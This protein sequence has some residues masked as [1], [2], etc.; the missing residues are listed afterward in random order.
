MQVDTA[1]Q[2][3]T[4]PSIRR[5]ILQGVNI[6]L[7]YIGLYVMAS[8]HCVM[9]D[10]I[11][12][13]GL[14]VLAGIYSNRRWVTYSI[15][16]HIIGC[17]MIDVVGFYSVPY[18]TGALILFLFMR[19]YPKVNSAVWVAVTLTLVRLPIIVI[20][21]FNP[22][23]ASML[24]IE[25]GLSTVLLPILQRFTTRIERPYIKGA[26]DCQ[27]LM[28]LFLVMCIAIISTAEMAFPMDI[29]LSAMLCG[30][31]I[32]LM[33]L[34]GGF[35][36]GG[37]TGIILGVVSGLYLSPDP[38]IM[39]IYGV[40]GLLCGLV[41]Q[42]GKW[43]VIT[44]FIL[45]SCMFIIITPLKVPMAFTIG[46]QLAAAVLILL[47]SEKT[48]NTLKGIVNSYFPEPEYA[49]RLKSAVNDRLVQTSVALDRLSGY[50]KKLSH[51]HPDAPSQD[52]FT[53][54]DKAANRVCKNCISSSNCWQRDY[55]V[56]A[57]ALMD[58]SHYLEE[59]GYIEVDN[60]PSHL[61]NRCEKI[62][63][64][65]EQVN[66]EYESY[67]INQVLH[68]KN[69]I[70]EDLAARQIK[71]FSKIIQGINN[72][73][74]REI[75]FDTDLEKR[76]LE[77]LSPLPLAIHS[78]NAVIDHTGRYSITITASS[79]TGATIEEITQ[80]ISE[81]SGKEMEPYDMTEEHNKVTLH[82]TQAPQYQLEYG[83][84]SAPKDGQTISGDSRI[85]AKLNDGRV[86]MAISD[87]MGSGE[88]AARQ[89]DATIELLGKFFEA[90]FDTQAALRMINSILLLRSGAESFATLD[91]AIIDKYSAKCEFIKIGANCGYVLINGKIKKIPSGS[92]PA[93]ILTEVDIERT[94]M[95]L[96]DNSNIVLISDGIESA[97]DP[98]V[99]KYVKDNSS[100]TPQQLAD[101]ILKQ[102]CERLGGV[103]D[104]MTVIIGKFSKKGQYVT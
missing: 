49:T 59:V 85:I 62:E 87:G 81:V 33:S 55:D 48:I 47:T 72:R 16:M 7:I 93:G 100:S 30:Y 68:K 1:S 80:C 71:D 50:M 75:D 35:T 22:Y 57:E 65:T 18:I 52:I 99:A 88:S 67:R 94:S 84:A 12:P 92:L 103:E 73:L 82:F 91:I 14:C 8:A 56:T 43:G 10:A 28:G 44:G 31:I 20:D 2:T 102:A 42:L 41:R 95:S 83:E 5:Y 104:D 64:F 63:K 61:R 96:T 51:T 101:D 3:K 26:P 74:T 66:K 29:N 11:A 9:F 37:A 79:K 19:L 17:L 27:D 38:A 24:V 40:C 32:M 70:S 77:N 90:G 15:I 23:D 53:V 36:F 34:A 89:S 25:I 39:G 69:S 6:P 86:I 21:G 76:L 78:I 98:W 54:F 46:E 58:S 45:A 4:K 60:F 13:F 97:N